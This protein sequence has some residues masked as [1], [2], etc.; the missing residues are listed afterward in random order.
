MAFDPTTRTELSAAEL[1]L[2]VNDTPVRLHGGPHHAHKQI[3]LNIVAHI[4]L[5]GPCGLREL[6]D[7]FGAH[8]DEG[9][10]QTI[11]RLRSRL[12]HLTDSGQIVSTGKAAMRRWRAPLADA[13]P[14]LA[15]VGP[16]VPP[17]TYDCMRG[18][19]Y[20]PERTT[21]PRQGSDDFKR[22]PSVGAR[23]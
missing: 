17:R 16:V 10:A 7:L 6:Y 8:A 1:A 22:L 20:V 19:T 21:A 12:G 3:N 15:W 9:H 2:T 13:Q 11:E 18:A 14:E 5:Y 4:A 23:C